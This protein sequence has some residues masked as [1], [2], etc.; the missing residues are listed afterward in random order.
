MLNKA[1]LYAFVLVFG[2]CAI[3]CGSDDSGK[4]A[5]LKPVI[6][7]WGP[8][9]NSTEQE[10]PKVTFYD[11]VWDTSK[12]HAELVL[13]HDGSGWKKVRFNSY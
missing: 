7:D 11:Y 5:L 13:S 6:D 8:P 3:S 9:T 1:M 10:Y 2:A 4:D 12:G